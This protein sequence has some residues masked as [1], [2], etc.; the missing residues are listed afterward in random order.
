[1]KRLR[2]YSFSLLF[3]L[4]SFCAATGAEA[5][6]SM[7]PYLSTPI[8]MSN[9]VP[10]NVLIIFDNSGSMNQMAYWE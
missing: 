6:N 2:T 1:M 9:A 4:L 3:I 8:F 7:A 10:P 5:A